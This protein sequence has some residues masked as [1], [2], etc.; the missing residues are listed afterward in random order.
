MLLFIKGVVCC[1]MLDNVNE[2]YSKLLMQKK[3]NFVNYWSY[4]VL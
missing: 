2:P 4:S 1:F 3:A